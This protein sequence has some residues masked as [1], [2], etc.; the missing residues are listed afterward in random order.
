MH[1]KNNQSGTYDF[2]TYINNL[3]N[4]FLVVL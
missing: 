4:K 3:L 2:V 1:A